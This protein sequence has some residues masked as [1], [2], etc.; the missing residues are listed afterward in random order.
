MGNHTEGN[1]RQIL[2][3]AFDERLTYSTKRLD[4]PVDDQPVNR[5]RDLDPHRA[6][7]VGYDAVELGRSDAAVTLVRNE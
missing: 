1:R 6:V 7:S 2:K 3:N 4:A 5:S